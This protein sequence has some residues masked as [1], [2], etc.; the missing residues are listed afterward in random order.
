MS[1]PVDKR[2]SNQQQILHFVISF[3]ALFQANGTRYVHLDEWLSL[4]IGTPTESHNYKDIMKYQP[5]GHTSF[6]RQFTN[7]VVV[8]NPA[9]TTDTGVPLPG[10]YHSCFPGLNGLNGLLSAGR[11]MHASAPMKSV[12]VQAHTGLL[13]LKEDCLP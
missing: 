6:V 13:M 9:N 5:Q 11:K 8:V 1:I 7:G 2:R 3:F 10:E 4:K 12:D